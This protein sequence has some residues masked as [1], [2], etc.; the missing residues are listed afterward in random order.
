MWISIWYNYTL[1]SGIC[2][3]TDSLEKILLWPCHHK[4][5]A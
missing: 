4:H 1:K 3:D 5:V 2:P